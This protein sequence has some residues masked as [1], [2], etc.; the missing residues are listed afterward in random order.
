MK[1][2]CLVRQE[3]PTFPSGTGKAKS[4]Q[5]GNGKNTDDKAQQD[6]FRSGKK[7]RMKKYCRSARHKK[8]TLRCVSCREGE[9]ILHLTMQDGTN[10]GARMQVTNVRKSLMSV[11][12]TKRCRAGRV[13]LRIKPK[14]C[15]SPKKKKQTQ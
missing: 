5:G 1:K 7:G 6:C 10:R 14:L 4:G 15:G 12:D 9:R 11:A 8:W 2:D 13:L 3:R